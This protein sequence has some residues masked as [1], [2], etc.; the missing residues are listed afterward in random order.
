M[1]TVH[2]Q[3]M[4]I[5]GQEKYSL[6]VERP[7]N[8]ARQVDAVDCMNS[9]DYGTHACCNS[10]RHNLLDEAAFHLDDWTAQTVARC[11]CVAANVGQ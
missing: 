3:P 8:S 7:Y 10:N 9:S 11:S 6:I 1:H 2:A 4:K 5:R